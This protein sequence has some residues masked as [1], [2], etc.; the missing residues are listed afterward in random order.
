MSAAEA[1]VRT[2][3]RDSCFHAEAGGRLAEVER[4]LGGVRP[5]I[6]V[7]S[8]PIAKRRI[9]GHPGGRSRDSTSERSLLELFR[10]LRAAEATT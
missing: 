3:S 6:N 10:S 9:S 8:L 5:S 4:T 2:A 7:P 1:P